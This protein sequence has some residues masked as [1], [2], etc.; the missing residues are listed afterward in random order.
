MDP[1]RDKQ[2]TVPRPAA[3]IRPEEILDDREIAEVE[4]QTAPQPQAVPERTIDVDAA[5]AAEE[6]PEAAPEP[7][8]GELQLTQCP[9]CGADLSTYQERVPDA[10]E[11]GNWLRHILGEER[12]RKHYERLGGRLVV[13]LRSR[14]VQENDDMFVQLGREMADGRLD[15]SR[16]MLRLNRLMLAL[17]LE[18]MVIDDGGQGTS[19]SFPEVTTDTY[20]SEVQKGDTEGVSATDYPVARAYDKMVEKLGE[21]RLDAL[22]DCLHDFEQMQTVLMRHSRDKD[23]WEPTGSCT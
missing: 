7:A 8:A 23:F 9:A 4:R 2:F 5:L 17:S 1:K 19:Q 15:N 11:K 3:A 21:G 12:F 10:E 20:P 18:R 16:Y 22:L 6:A 14:T 13:Q